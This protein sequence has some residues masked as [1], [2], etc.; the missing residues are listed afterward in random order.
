MGEDNEN[1][2]FFFPLY[3]SHIITVYTIYVYVLYIHTR[4]CVYITYY[5]TMCIVVGVFRVR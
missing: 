2:M 4:V 1:S 3:S 5:Y